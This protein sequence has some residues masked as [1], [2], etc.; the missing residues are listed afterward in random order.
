MSSFRCPQSTSYFICSKPKIPSSPITHPG[1]NA[2]T[3]CL[4]KRMT[5]LSIYCPSRNLDVLLLYHL[6]FASH[7]LPSHLNPGPSL[8]PDCSFS[9]LLLLSLSPVQQYLLTCLP[10]FRFSLSTQPILQMQQERALP[11]VKLLPSVPLLIPPVTN[12]KR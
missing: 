11:H 1:H 10:C 6:S 7:Q 5:S 12:P 2:C 8:S 4:L 3:I 9:S